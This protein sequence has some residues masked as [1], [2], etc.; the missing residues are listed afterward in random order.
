MIAG[1]VAD[2]V[3]FGMG[4]NSRVD[5]LFSVLPTTAV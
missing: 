5:A 4:V 3:E 2:L 1:Q